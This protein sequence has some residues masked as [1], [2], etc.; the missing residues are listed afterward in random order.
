MDILLLF[1]VGLNYSLP[2]NRKLVCSGIA[3]EGVE[4]LDYNFNDF[5][6]VEH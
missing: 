4:L 1:I 2:S 3:R 5:A 6:E